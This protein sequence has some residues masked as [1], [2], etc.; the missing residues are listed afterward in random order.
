[1][2]KGVIVAEEDVS[3]VGVTSVTVVVADD[4]VPD[5]PDGCVCVA[6]VAVLV[7]E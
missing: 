7:I 4:G 6:V 2:V 3:S 1:M 5:S